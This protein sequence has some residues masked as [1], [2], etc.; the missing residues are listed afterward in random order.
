[1]P[2]SKDVVI[3]ILKENNNRLKEK[4]YLKKLYLFGSVSRGETAND[5]DILIEY[6]DKFSLFT[7][8]Y[9]SEDL[10]KILNA[11]VDIVSKTGVSKEFYQTIEDDLIAI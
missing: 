11:K 4:Y 10:E 6:D 9:L 2:P 8:I 1:M 5:V 3:S 7:K